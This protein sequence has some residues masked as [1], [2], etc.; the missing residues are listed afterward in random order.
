MQAQVG[1]RTKTAEELAE[2]ERLRLEALEAQRVK[3]MRAG[4]LGT[5]SSC[6]YPA[7]LG[8]TFSWLD[9]LTVHRALVCLPL[10]LLS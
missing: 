9:I 3:R 7:E 5:T 4:T 2:L 10:V 6:M 1:E 8:A